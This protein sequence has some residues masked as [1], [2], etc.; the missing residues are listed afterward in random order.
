MRIAIV[1]ALLALAA[2]VQVQPIP[3]PQDSTC[4]TNVTITTNVMATVPVSAF[5]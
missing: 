3:C 2:C 4:S 5:P 1:A